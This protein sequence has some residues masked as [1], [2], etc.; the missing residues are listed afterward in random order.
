MQ[1]MRRVLQQR[2]KM[3]QTVVFHLI[4]IRVDMQ[5]KWSGKIKTIKCVNKW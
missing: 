4:H 1:V 2:H 3:R 5:L